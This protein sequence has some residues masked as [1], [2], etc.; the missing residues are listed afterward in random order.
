MPSQEFFNQGIDMCLYFLNKKRP[1]SSTKMKK[2]IT[3]SRYVG[4]ALILAMFMNGCSDPYLQKIPKHQKLTQ[5]ELA[6]LSSGLSQEDKVAL[7]NWANR[8]N[9]GEDFGGEVSAL[10]VKE[11]IIN[12]KRFEAI[13]MAARAEKRKKEKEIEAQEKEKQESILNAAARRQAVN[14]VINEIFKIKVVSYN[15]TTQFNNYG[16]ESGRTWNFNLILQNMSE[17][18]AIGIAGWI[19]I[20]DIFNNELGTYPVKLEVNVPKGKIINFIAVMPFDRK[21]PG[22]IEMIRSSKF[23]T[24]FF[25]ESLAF[26]NGSVIDENQ[27]EIGTQLEPTKTQK[28][29]TY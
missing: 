27:L 25:F 29:N 13:Q 22:Q 21:D 4:L 6:E 15:L 1:F 26:A 17:T 5:S 19:T 9:I 2:T 12:Q 14:N 20:H 8:K 24:S 3:F 23:K 11:A 18:E 10:T 28:N 7:E 16:Y